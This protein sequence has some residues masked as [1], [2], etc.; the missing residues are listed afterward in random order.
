MRQPGAP[1]WSL[2]GALATKLAAQTSQVNRNRVA[3][4]V[5]GEGLARA[6]L[7]GESGA[8][9]G[10]AGLLRSYAFLGTVERLDASLCLL[11]RTLLDPKNA[12]ALCC[13]SKKPPRLNAATEA[14]APR[15]NASAADRARFDRHHAA[16]R[17]VYGAANRV[18]GVRLRA[19]AVEGW[20]ATPASCGC[21][22]V[23]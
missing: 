1:N 14:C 10:A 13:A 21:A 19:A 3:Q 11:G 20:G 9:D 22:F 8:A 4:T 2:A 18:L 12:C 5:L 16:D 7:H 15:L 23:S 17:F 6:L